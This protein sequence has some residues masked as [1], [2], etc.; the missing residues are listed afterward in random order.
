MIPEAA[1]NDTKTS[2]MSDGSQHVVIEALNVPVAERFQGPRRSVD[3]HL[4][5]AIADE[6][7]IPVSAVEKYTDDRRSR[8]MLAINR[9]YCFIIDS[10]LRSQQVQSLRKAT[11]SVSALKRRAATTPS[12]ILI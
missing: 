12:T 10:M 9:I 5:Q 6:L 2:R 8:L 3:H 4:H 7:N 1:H 11:A